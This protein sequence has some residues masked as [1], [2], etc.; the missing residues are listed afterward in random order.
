M[1]PYIIGVP[2]VRAKVMG[3]VGDNYVLL[4]EYNTID[5]GGNKVHVKKYYYRNQWFIE[6]YWADTFRLPGH[7]DGQ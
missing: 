2:S 3:L 5:E 7:E 1:V 6:S 4:Q